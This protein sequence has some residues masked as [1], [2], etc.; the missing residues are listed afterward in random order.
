MAINSVSLRL[1]KDLIKM[2]KRL[3]YR[4]SQLKQ[5]SNKTF[6]IVINQYLHFPRNPLMDLKI[7]A[8]VHSLM[9][10]KTMIDSCQAHMPVQYA[11]NI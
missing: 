6:L 5:N 9:N 2:L 8:T 4:N 3:L 10:C 7:F 1:K 11:S